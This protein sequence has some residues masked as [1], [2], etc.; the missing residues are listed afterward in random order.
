SPTSSWKLSTHNDARAPE[1][2][3]PAI[4][5][6]LL[7]KPLTNDA[8]KE[9]GELLLRFSSDSKWFFLRLQQDFL[10]AIPT[11]A[12]KRLPTTDYEE[13]IK[14]ILSTLIEFQFPQ[15]EITT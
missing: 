14:R 15:D 8:P 5:M 13:T 6:T 4:I 9:N 11:D 1:L 2:A 3:P 12:S 10:L 7:K